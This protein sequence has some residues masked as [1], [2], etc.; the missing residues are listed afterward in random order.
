MGRGI[1]YY[2]YSVDG[3]LNY[4][5]DRTGN[6]IAT[7]YN[8]GS[9][10]VQET[11]SATNGNTGK[12][13]TYEYDSLSR[14]KKIS[15][16][17]NDQVAWTFNTAGLVTNET[18][19]I[20]AVGGASGNIVSSLNYSY[21]AF[22]RN[23]GKQLAVGGAIHYTDAM[24]YDLRDRLTRLTRTGSGN[25]SENMWTTIQYDAMDAIVGTQ[26]AGASPG[27]NSGFGIQARDS[28]ER[29]HS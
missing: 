12:T 19:T 13:R 16:G 25:T 1:R 23:T 26:R 17:A 22:G 4:S 9:Q 27:S 18:T 6:Q 28:F 10:P 11:W 3:L 15:D 21:D 20:P 24:A 7:T 29:C 5:T 14:L 8:V 2:D